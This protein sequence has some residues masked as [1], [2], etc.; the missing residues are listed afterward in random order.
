MDYE[1]ILTS[2]LETKSSLPKLVV[3][4]GPTAC[5]K[6]NLSL[7]VARELDTEIISTD[8]KQIYKNLDIWTGK[9][10]PDE[11]KGI[12]H[13]MIDIKDASEVYS[14]GE[15]QREADK[16]IQELYK[17]NKVPVL[18]GGTG[19]YIDSIIYDFNIPKIPA[20]ETLRQSLEE[21]AEK[22]GNEHIYKHLQEIDP[23]YAAELHP[24][25]LHYVIRGIEVQ[26]SFWKI[27]TW[28]SRK[29]RA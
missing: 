11:T 19:L 17:N 12:I 4:Y 23:E 18:C 7:S 13:H 26:N 22:Y 15:F 3:I 9:I 6:T 21:E 10:L 5:W 24:N 16:I 27:K 8:S 28:I 1:S 29:K 14:V 25:N 2:F 20:N